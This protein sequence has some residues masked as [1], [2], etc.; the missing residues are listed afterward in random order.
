[1]SEEK[2]MLKIIHSLDFQNTHQKS[3]KSEWE[4]ITAL[5]YILSPS[6]KI[7]TIEISKLYL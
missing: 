1:M 3:H 7:P 6:P 5:R 4:I 2:R